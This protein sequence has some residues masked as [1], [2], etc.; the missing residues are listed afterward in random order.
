MGLDLT[1]VESAESGRRSLEA[2]RRL[3]ERR[4]D[5][6]V[7][8]QDEEEALVRILEKCEGAQKAR[9]GV[10]QEQAE[11]LEAWKKLL[12]VL[13]LPEELTP[14]GALEVIAGVER[15]QGQLRE[16]REAARE[17]EQ[18]EL[19]V[20]G[21]VARLNRVLEQCGWPTVPLEESPSALLALRKALG[22]SLASEQELSR[23]DEVLAEKREE[24]EAGEGEKTR[25]VDQLNALLS[26]GGAEEA[27][28]FRRRAVLSRRQ[29]ELERQSRQLE[30][31]L[32]VHAGSV[33]RYHDMERIFAKKSRA[34]LEREL[35][36][37]KIEGHLVDVLAKNLQENGR[38]AQQLQDLEQNE[39]LSTVMLE[40]QTLL[41]QLD[42]QS[43]RWAIRVICQHLLDKARQVYERE[44][45]PA[46][47]RE[48]SK[49]FAI[50]TNNRYM[51]VIVPLGE[52]RLA[53]ETDKGTF[54][55]TEVL[56]RGT[57]EQLYL[58]MRLAFIREYAQH[59][60][61]LPI[62]IDDIFVNF[63]PNRAKATIKVIG[64]LAATHQVLVF[65][66]HPHV[67]RWFEEMLEGVSIRDIPKN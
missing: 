9:C 6:N 3:V 30:I 35:Q 59:A 62:V 65:T 14:D 42:Q 23:V 43:Q 21:M 61:P 27:E 47:L 29:I 48:A 52:M 46:I 12:S 58:A 57:A 28:T 7:R 2:E 19:A 32:Q 45:Q 11:A 18:V 5:I 53:V 17:L 8:V 44:R 60:G 54:R 40:R 26:A 16:W 33:D 56:S 1:S 4:E 49:F 13:G 36:E 38:V 55:P 10:E 63:D 66:C 25:F 20:N 39:R 22:Q 67:R 15:A 37:V 51:R 41:S 64:M 31:A 34:E 50:M 24:L